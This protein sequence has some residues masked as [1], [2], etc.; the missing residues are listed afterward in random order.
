MAMMMESE[1]SFTRMVSE[2]SLPIVLRTF[3]MLK[4]GC[5]RVHENRNG[6]ILP[7]E[8]DAQAHVSIASVGFETFASHHQRDECHVRAIHRLKGDSIA[9]TF[10]RRFID[11]F[12]Q[13]FDH[14]GE[15]GTV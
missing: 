5:V 2:S 13:T 15:D 10:P 14:F 11:Q 6:E 1:S 12:T 8:T 7:D 4:E 3:D 9:A